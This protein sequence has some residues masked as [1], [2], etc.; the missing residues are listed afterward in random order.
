MSTFA[1]KLLALKARRNRVCAGE[2]VRVSPDKALSVGAATALVISVFRELG[3]ERVWDPSRIVLI[4]DHETPAQTILDANAHKIVR[5]FA[6]EQGIARFYDVGE[7]VCHQVMLEKGLVAPSD[8]ILGKDSHTTSYGAIGAFGTPV[9]ATEM[10]CLWATGETWLRVPESIKIELLGELPAGVSGKDVILHILGRL[11]AEGA[12]YL[13]VEFHGSGVAQLSVSDR[14]TVAIMSVEMGAKNC[15]FP[16]DPVTASFMRQISNRPLTTVLPDSDASYRQILQVGLHSLAPQVACPH[17]VDNVKEV[18]AVE[19]LP[20][21]Q[22]FIGSCTNGRFDDLLMA[23]NLL[24]GKRIHPGV[25]LIIG[26]A[27]RQ[28]L[29]DATKAGLIELFLS[30]GAI[31]LPPGCGPCYGSHSG[32]LADGER[33]L[34]TINRN[35]RGRMGNPNAEVY[36]SSTATA[37]VSAVTG[38]ITDPRKFLKTIS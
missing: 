29:I 12:T 10:G 28:I 31:V 3:V 27:S 2:I 4:L 30:A 13:S 15:V 18:G 22:V 21:D 8:L 14:M 5:E 33:C 6:K 25:R 37:A 36:L 7:G 26:P 38:E 34:A 35:F 24:R 9:D 23:A 1:E 20:I 11:T 32:I 19:G 16:A 17:E